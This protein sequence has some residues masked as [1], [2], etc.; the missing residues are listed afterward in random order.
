[1]PDLDAHKADDEARK[2]AEE[3]ELIARL[4]EAGP[5][6]VRERLAKALLTADH[7]R[8]SKLVDRL[9]RALDKQGLRIVEKKS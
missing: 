8:T 7:T 3:K 5:E 2:L 6:N 9:I 4:L 1:M